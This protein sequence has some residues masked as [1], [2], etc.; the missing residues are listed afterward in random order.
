MWLSVVLLVLFLFLLVIFG[1]VT[2]ARWNF[3][4]L[5]NQGIPVVKP[6]HFLLGGAMLSFKKVGGLLDLEHMKKYGPIFGVRY[7]NI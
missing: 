5:E 4:S 2:Y 7:I 1:L 3:G 6:H